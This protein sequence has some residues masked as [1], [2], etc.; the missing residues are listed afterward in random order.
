[1]M[2][3]IGRGVLFTGIGI[4]AGSGG[5]LA[6]TRFLQ[7]LLYETPPYDPLVL[8]AVAALLLLASVVASVLPALRATR[9]EISR[10][11]RAE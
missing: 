11:L 1:M 8:G 5:A 2:L 3:I 4:V 7:S 10:L 6:L 9:A